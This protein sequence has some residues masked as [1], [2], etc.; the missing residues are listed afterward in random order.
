M[1]PFFKAAITS[2]I[3]LVFMT[4]AAI[5]AMAAQEVPPLPTG[6]MVI[7][8]VGGLAL[9]LYGMDHLAS[10]LKTLAAARLRRILSGLTRNRI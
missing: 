1:A 8:L 6:A 10:A 5:P 2:T 9:F 3:L 7:G 4:V